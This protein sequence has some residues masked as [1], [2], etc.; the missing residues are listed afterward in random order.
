MQSIFW[1]EKCPS[2]LGVTTCKRFQRPVSRKRHFS[3]GGGQI[4][5]LFNRPVCVSDNNQLQLAPGS[6]CPV[7]LLEARDHQAYMFPPFSCYL[8][9]LR[10]E[11]ASAVLVAPVWSNQLLDYPI[12][13]LVNW[14]GEIHPVVHQGHLPLAT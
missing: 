10:I 12:V 14:N 8:E 5:T 7:T 2:R 1:E 4:R 6:R 9:K 13:I 3:P 11:Q